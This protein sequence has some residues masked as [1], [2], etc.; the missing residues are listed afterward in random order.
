MSWEGVG[1]EILINV[2]EIVGF[3][4]YIVGINCHRWMGVDIGWLVKLFIGLL[5]NPLSFILDFDFRRSR[6]VFPLFGQ[7]DWERECSK[8]IEP[9]VLQSSFI[10]LFALSKKIFP[11]S[12]QNPFLFSVKPIGNEPNKLIMFMQYTSRRGFKIS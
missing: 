11:P 2:L 4:Q 9:F 7:G 6:I 3:V 8:E 1:W 5:Y 12:K 10:S